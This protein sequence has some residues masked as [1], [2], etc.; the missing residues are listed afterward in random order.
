MKKVE[1]RL[2]SFS[3]RACSKL[4]A[5]ATAATLAVGGVG[6]GSSI[7]TFT[8]FE[9]GMKNVQATSQATNTEF[10]QL[11]NTAKDLGAKTSFSAKEASDGMNY[12]AMAGFKTNEIIS[13]MPGLLDLAA[14]AGSDLGVT[15]D[16]VSDAITA[17]GL[18]AKDTTHLADV[19]AKA[20]STAN[21]NVEMLG[22]AYKYAAAPAHAFG[23]SAEEVT[24]ALAKMADAGVKG[25]MGG[26]ALRGA[27]TRLAKPPKQAAKWLKKLGVNIADTHGKIRPFN[28]I[29]GDMRKSMSKLTQQQKQ[30]AVASIFGQE[31]MSGM[32]AVLNTSTEDFEKY[33][34]SLKKADGTA[35]E[36]AKTKLDSLGGQFTILKS[37]V[38]GMQ[39]ELG[40]RL[41]P[42]A[43]QFVTWFT[44]KIPDITNGIIKIVDKISQLAHKFNEL[45][46][47]TKKFIGYLAAG[48]VLFNPLNRGITLATKGIKG[49]IGLTGRVGK[50]FGI[51][52]GATAAVEATT[53]VAAGAEAVAGATT[54]MGT[55]T[56][57]VA[58]SG[59]L[60]TLGASLGSIAAPVAIA[61]AGIA[62]L[63]YGGYK[64]KK[65]LEADAVPA[66]DLF[67]DRIEKTA[68]V[69]KQAVGGIAKSYQ[70]MS[71]EISKETKK[72]VGAY[73]ELDKQTSKSLVDINANS[74]KFT[75][76]T[77]NAVIKNFSDMV[78]KSSNKGKDLNAKMIKEFRNLVDNTTIA[79]EENKTAIINEYTSMVNGCSKLTK[80][81]KSDTINNFV[82]TFKETTGIT[83]QQKNTLIAKYNEMG[84]QI[85]SGYDKQYQERN[86]K[87]QNFFAKSSVFTAQRQSEI[88]QAERN[89][90]EGLKASTQEYCDKISQII[91]TA[92]NEHRQLRANE[93]SDIKM[94]QDNMRQNAVESLSKNEIETK[95][96]L[97]R[98]KSYNTRITAEQAAE[99][100]KNA[101]QQR[102]QTVDEANRQFL[103]T[104][105]AFEQARDITKSCTAEEA[106]EAISAAA[107]MRDETVAHA[108]AQKEEVV[109]KVT[110]MDSEISQNVNTTTGE[111]ISNSE[112]MQS[113]WD[114]WN[115]KEHN[116]VVNFFHKIFSSKEEISNPKKQMT[117]EEFLKMKAQNYASGTNFATSGVHE[118]A[119]HGFEIVVGRQHRLFNGGEKVL[120]H[121]KSKQF[122]KDT[123]EIPQKK[124]KPQFA[125]A[126]PQLAGVGGGNVNV[127]VD[128]ENNFDNDTDIDG[129]VQKAMQ[130]FG[131]KLKE[132]L[133]NV[134]K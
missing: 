88:L 55:A 44:A 86:T 51:F 124:P 11:W 108:N 31:A 107:R 9:Q 91:Q 109:S 110:E 70:K 59:A 4:A 132:A 130:E 131:Y 120:N 47:A 17:F 26:T 72:A 87:L 7:K 78:N 92:N 39:I 81:Q 104:K 35:K 45:S 12:L 121:R 84:Q 96:I 3:K 32:L 61:V 112:R 25:T 10:K 99:A 63:G 48:V 103:E 125:I 74:I 43:K 28:S 42:Y 127:D 37:A 122:L 36:M 67:A 8:N 118:V 62:A 64:L 73:M 105:S 1:G 57:T 21:T 46:P 49:M 23:M 2:S 71:V 30:Q 117:R 19:M 102:V 15:S 33:T 18:K 98:L 76:N 53:T 24:A 41:A 119:E 126:Q 94:Y 56:A 6:I 38:E 52:K 14:A 16:I 113:T 66:V 20:S 13:A 89:H 40:E 5:V 116:C 65:H 128:V 101:E 93:L 75:A 95:V 68:I 82:K 129:I 29:M 27:L 106:D 34:Q 100:I 111:V 90:N 79:S 69:N 114:N 133:K 60:G 83:E 22:E 115:P 77:K 50:F 134:K 85:N 54:A 97:E 123:N 80:K 58:G